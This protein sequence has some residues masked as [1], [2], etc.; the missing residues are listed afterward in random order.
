MFS[1]IVEETRVLYMFFIRTLTP[2]TRAPPLVCSH[3]L[4]ALTPGIIMLGI[5]LQSEFESATNIHYVVVPFVTILLA[6][7]LEVSPPLFPSLA[8]QNSCK[9]YSVFVDRISYFIVL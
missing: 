1:S 7:H 8:S 3:L 5:K 2:L 6:F 4:K 9:S